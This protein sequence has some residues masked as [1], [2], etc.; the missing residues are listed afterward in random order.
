MSKHHKIRW[1]DADNQEL[2]KVVRNFNA[3]ISRLA[4]KNPQ[5]KNVLP[6]KQSV[7]QLK[8]LI[9][10]RADLKRELN[11]LKRFSKRGAEKIVVVPNTDYNLT[12]TK[13]QKVE[14]NR[15]IGIINRRRKKR[16][17]ELE[18]IEVESRGEAAGYTRGELG[19][20]RLEKV[21]L[22]PMNAF[23][24]RMTQADIKWKWAS[25]MKQSQSDYFNE[26]DYQ[27]RDNFIKTLQENYNTNDIKDVIDRIN[28]M[29]IGDFLNEFH[30][31]PAAF[32]WAYPPNQEQYEGYVSS[33][34]AT[35]TPKRK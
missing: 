31:D 33:L 2:A 26:R 28:N 15:R 6:E 16:L 19:M 1:T 14:M 22:A 18:N 35:Y 21:E 23:T 29:D 9:N 3:K 27:L 10:T 30:K 8:E 7:R 11:A 34:K 4:K 20:G 32:E 12:L 24:R 13:W 5:I 25:V 17:E